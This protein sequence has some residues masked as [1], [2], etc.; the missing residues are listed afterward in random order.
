MRWMVPPPLVLVNPVA[1]GGRAP[2]L[3]RRLEPRIRKLWPGLTLRET[4]APGDAERVAREVPAE[5]LLVFGGDGTLHEAVNGLLDGGSARPLAV[6]PAGTGNDFARN[7][8]LPL[9]PE[10]VVDRL[11]R[12]VPRR[13]DLGRVRFRES[14]VVRT[15][16]FLNSASTGVSARA[17]RFAWRMRKLLPG[18]IRYPVAGAVALLAEGRGLFRVDLGSERIFEGEALNLTVANCAS[19]GGGLRISP[20]SSP[21][22]GVLDLVVIGKLGSLRAL[23]ALSRLRSG[24]HVGMSGVSTRPAPGGV[25]IVRDD[26]KGMLLEADG[27]DFVA[28]GEVTVD[29][30][31]A[32]LTLLA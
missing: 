18:R 4:T 30:L 3:W 14:G 5:L 6:I 27:H 32:G 20:A 2:A 12:A 8:G 1:A 16:L 23:L 11:A 10:A 22:D 25:R 19:F 21:E 31:P 7:T 24:G 15:R 13:V 17:N 28:D 26:G 9:D 29:V